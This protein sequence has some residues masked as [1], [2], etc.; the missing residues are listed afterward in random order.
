MND[1]GLTFHH[2]G[3]AVRTP[4]AAAAFLGGLGYSLGPSVY[5]PRQNVLLQMAESPGGP[6]VEI[7]SPGEGPGP[8]DRLITR[9]SDGLIYHVCA[10]L[11]AIC[12][13]EPTPAVLFGGRPVSFY[14]VQGLGLIEVIEGLIE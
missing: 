7:I 14:T 13:S 9:H 1:F 5:D 6:T 11:R 3:L 10:G 12:V 2:L 4:Q 8:I